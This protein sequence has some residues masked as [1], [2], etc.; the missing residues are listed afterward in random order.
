MGTRA[1][2]TIANKTITLPTD[3]EPENK[4]EIYAQRNGS[5]ALSPEVLYELYAL[6]C[7]PDIMAVIAVYDRYSGLWNGDYEDVDRTVEQLRQEL[8]EAGIEEVLY[9][10]NQLLP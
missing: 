9:K 4:A 7:D 3:L 6:D 1:L 5:A 10:L 8:E 2:N